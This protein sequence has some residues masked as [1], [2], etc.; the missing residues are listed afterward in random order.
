MKK[1]RSN[2][3]YW[4]MYVQ[5]YMLSIARNLNNCRTHH[6]PGKNSAYVKNN[7]MLSEKAP[8]EEL[9]EYNEKRLQ[10]IVGT[11]LYYTRAIYPTMLMALNSLVVVQTNLTIETAKQITQFLNY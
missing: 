8:S 4:V 6:T 5:H 7:H 1:E 10:K 2:F 9:Y 3:Q 11:L